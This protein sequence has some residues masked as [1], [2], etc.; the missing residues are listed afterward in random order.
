MLY[1]Q[2]QDEPRGAIYHAKFSTYSKFSSESI[3]SSQKN[4]T[5]TFVGKDMHARLPRGMRF[6]VKKNEVPD[7]HQF[8][9]DFCKTLNLDTIIFGMIN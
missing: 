1:F 8:E 3:A 9:M 6:C 7:L 4:G 2:T 5:R